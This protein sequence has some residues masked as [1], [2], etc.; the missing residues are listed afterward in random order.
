MLL[1]MALF[2]SFF[3]LNNIPLC[4]CVCVCVYIYAIYMCMC[5]YIY[6]YNF[7]FLGHMEVPGLGV[8]PEPH[9]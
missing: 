5:V 1:Q 8:E 4:I 7:L 3:W 2:H 6:I 9:L